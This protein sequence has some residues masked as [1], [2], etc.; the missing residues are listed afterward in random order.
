M[1]LVAYDKQ[2]YRVSAK[3]ALQILTHASGVNELQAKVRGKWRA[4]MFGR[5]RENAEYHLVQIRAAIN[6]GDKTYFVR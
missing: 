3:T 1:I 5:L 2:F 4:I 6:R